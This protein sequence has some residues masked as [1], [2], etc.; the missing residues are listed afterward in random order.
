MAKIKQEPSEEEKKDIPLYPI[1]IVAELV[2][3]ADADAVV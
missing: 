2:G 3:T 1:G